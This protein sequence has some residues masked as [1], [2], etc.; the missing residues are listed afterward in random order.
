ML[1]TLMGI[2]TLL[3]SSSQNLVAQ[4]SPPF[5]ELDLLAAFSSHIAIGDL[6]D[7]WGASPGVTLRIGSP[8]YAGSIAL[9]VHS[10]TFEADTPEQ[11]DFRMY[12]LTAEWN[13]EHDIGEMASTFIGAQIGS[14]GMSFHE[15]EHHRTE[16]EDENEFLT[17]A[18]VGVRST[19][20]RRLGASLILSH[21]KVFTRLPL[22]LT[23]VVI[24]LSYSLSTPD[25]LRRP[26]E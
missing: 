8:F 2:L 19:L 11:P 10:N 3:V 9:G 22:R 1:R 21:Q 23:T 14:A 18:Q 24:G 25:W 6:S 16:N 15:R 20:W 7:Y 5:S 4:T 12:A 17:G 13:A 26:L